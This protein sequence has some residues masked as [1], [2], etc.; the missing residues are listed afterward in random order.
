MKIN[1]RHFEPFKIIGRGAFGEVRVCKKKD[2]TAEIVAIKKMKKTEM[3]YKNQVN[4]VKAE[5]DILASSN[6]QWIVDLKYS[7]QDEKFLYL[8]M[9]FLQGG[10]LM[11]LLM[12]KDI[13]TEEESRFYIAETVSFTLIS[14]LSCGECPSNEL[15]PQRLEARQSAV[16]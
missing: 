13:L 1:V 8:V 10:D 4:H 16:G 2:A 6:N 14:D 12:K 5:R 15:H 11:T 9:E 3:I 7:F